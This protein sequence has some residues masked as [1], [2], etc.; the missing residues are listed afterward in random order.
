VETVSSFWSG[1]LRL[2][3][4]KTLGA[5][6]TDLQLEELARRAGGWRQLVR[7]TPEALEGLGARWDV[8]HQLR[9]APPLETRGRAL[10]RACPEYPAGLTTLPAPPPVL[11]VEGDAAALG[12]PAVAIVGT[13]HHTPYG[14]SVA[15]RIAWACA[16]AG[17]VVVSGMARGIDT[18][19]HGGALAA[20]GRTVAVLGH[21]LAHTAPVSNTRLRERIT[22][23]GGLLVTTWPDAVP[24]S[25]HTFP[26]RNRWIAALA[27]RVVVVEAPEHSGALHTARALAEEGREQDLYVVPGPLGAETWK[28]STALLQQ[29]AA[30]FV[31]IDDFV[32]ELVGET[33]GARH[34]DWL[35]ALF[36]GAPLPE[37]A[38]LRQVSAVALLR[39]LGRMEL[40]GRVV[41]LPGGRYAPAGADA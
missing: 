14:A 17:L 35:S 20:R 21:G 3:R 39:E 34:P 22:T 25:K 32:R 18:H 27:R 12:L 41:R 15:H 2:T 24:P 26:E 9:T 7:A 38:A 6:G 10:T 11:F 28:G 16:R 31:D 4:S 37:V 1:T 8:I 19:A 33:G 5:E 36:Q 40:E 23:E 30:P 29:G 13:R